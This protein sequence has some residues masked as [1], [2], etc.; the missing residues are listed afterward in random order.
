MRGKEGGGVSSGAAPG[1]FELRARREI[2]RSRDGWRR[3]EGR[4]NPLGGKE[5]KKALVGRRRSGNN[6]KQRRGEGKKES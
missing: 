2:A 3:K 5:G 4:R 1:T 6:L